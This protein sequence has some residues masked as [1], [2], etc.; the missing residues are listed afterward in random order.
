MT[1]IKSSTGRKPRDIQ[2]T[3]DETLAQQEELADLI[4]IKKSKTIQRRETAG[5]TANGRLDREAPE[6][7]A[8]REC[9]GPS[10]SLR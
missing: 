9:C 8:V 3:N 4:K 6:T 1:V 10:Q 5:G 2:P 7:V